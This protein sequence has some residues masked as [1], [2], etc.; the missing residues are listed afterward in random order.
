MFANKELGKEVTQEKLSEL[1]ETLQSGTL[2]EKT[3]LILDI[4]DNYKL[5]DEVKE[6]L[7]LEVD[8]VK[9]IKDNQ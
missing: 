6:L 8:L 5:T 2:E 1:K 4:I 9:N 7:R 3:K